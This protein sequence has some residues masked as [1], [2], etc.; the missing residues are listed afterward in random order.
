MSFQPK[1]LILL[2]TYNEANNLPSIVLAILTILPKTHILVVDDNSPDGTGRLADS[3]S[4]K[5]KDQVFVMHRA[6][7]QGLGK[8]Y[9]AAFR[10]AVD[11]GY[12]H[13]LQMDADFS[14]PVE[15]LPKLLAALK[16][17]DFVLGSRYVAG[18]G[19]SNWGFVRRLISRGG[20]FY[21]K[22]VL[23][24]KV[25]DLTGGLKAFHHRVVK[26]LLSAP[27]QSVGYHFQIETTV[28]ALSEGFTC[29]E[30]PFIF[31]E[32]QAGHSKMSKKIFFEAFWQSIKLRFSLKTSKAP[33]SETPASLL[34]TND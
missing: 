25:Q 2:P 3:L 24:Q 27:I 11:H 18:G 4:Q 8:A 5:Y 21:A 13:I 28:R 22:L 9:L 32:R 19:V 14:H 1:S 10:Y 20:N 33:L 23:G 16:N 6:A 29:K 7:K 34:P 12:E 31:Q 17:Y 26:F 30:V 15:V